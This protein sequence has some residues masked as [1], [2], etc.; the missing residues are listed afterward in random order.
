MFELTLML[1]AGE[2]NNSSK[3]VGD[4][5]YPQ[6]FSNLDCGPFRPIVE[7]VW[8]LSRNLVEITTQKT[9]DSQ[10]LVLGTSEL[11]THNR[12]RGYHRAAFR[13]FQIL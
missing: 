3:F 6:I 8:A 12:S 10:T 5:T 13:V 1:V 7:V 9:S 11:A 2:L 4:G